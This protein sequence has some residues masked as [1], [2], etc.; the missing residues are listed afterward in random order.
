MEVRGQEGPPLP[1]L[2]DLDGAQEAG[3]GAVEGVVIKYPPGLQDPGDL[4]DDLGQV[5]DVLQNV[6]TEN[7]AEGAVLERERLAR[8]RQIADVQ[9]AAPRVFGGD[10]DGPLGGI[11]AGRG[12]A[13]PGDL[14]GQE[15]PAAAHL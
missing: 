5:A 14:L 2:A 13:H 4:G 8:S 1:D 10:A 9:P 6:T 11:D 7:D 3:P 12:E 15:S